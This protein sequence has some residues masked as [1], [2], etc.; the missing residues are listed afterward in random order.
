VVSPLWRA[1]ETCE[2]AGLS[3]KATIERDLVEWNCNYGACKGL[4]SAH[5]HEPVP[6]WLTNVVGVLGRMTIAGRVLW[7]EKMAAKW[8]QR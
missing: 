4:T 1:R 5:I 2:L 8:C 7:T 3:E 6:G